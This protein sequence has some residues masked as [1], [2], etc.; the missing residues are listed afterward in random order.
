VV[1]MET[2]IKGLK[3]KLRAAESQWESSVSDVSLPA[4]KAPT[5]GL[6]YLRLYREVK[7]QES[8][9]QLFNKMVEIA[10]LDIVRDVAVVQVLD[11]ANPPE[12]RSNT[13][14]F[15]SLFAG[16]ITCFLMILVAFGREYIQT[17]KNREEEMSRLVV[18]TNYLKPW[19]D[20]SKQ[21]INKFKLTR[22]S[23]K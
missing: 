2:E 10:R 4:S 23:A 1:R 6:E 12:R 20:I 16:M 18:L 15:P 5:L 3:E 13:R 17:V 14:L 22:G 19:T 8:L 11:P 21:I 7:F 9:Y